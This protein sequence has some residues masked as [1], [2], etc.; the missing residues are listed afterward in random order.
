MFVPHFLPYMRASLSLSEPSLR[1]PPLFAHIFAVWLRSREPRFFPSLSDSSNIMGEVRSRIGTRH[2]PI[3]L[4]L[5]DE[6]MESKCLS[7]FGKVLVYFCP[8]KD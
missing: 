8:L 6:T 1:C 5:E 4:S 7:Y 3:L 2:S